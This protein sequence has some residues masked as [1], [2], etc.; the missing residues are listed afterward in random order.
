MLGENPEA[1]ETRPFPVTAPDGQP[2][3][4]SRSLAN[5]PAWQRFIVNIA[6]AMVNI[7]FGFLVMSILAA[8]LPLASTTVGRMYTE[9]EKEMAG[10]TISSADS[11]LQVGD[12]IL[13]VAGNRVHVF[14]QMYYQVVTHGSKPVLLEILRNGEKQEIVVAFPTFEESGMTFGDIDFVPTREESNLGNVCKHAFYKC[15]SVVR[16]V[17]ESFIDLL[18][19]KYTMDAVS[20][21]VGT[22]GAIS[23]AAKLGFANLLYIVVIISVNLGI[24]NLLPIPALDGSHV[25]ISFFEMVT[26]IKVPTRIVATIDMIGLMALL[27]FMAFITFKDISKIFFR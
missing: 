12:T 1:D 2:I 27:S 9:E 11:G 16:M 21:P 24:F 14:D 4:P 3:D 26:G 13:S 17:W 19:G 18:G 25:I 7:L 6:G 22:A 10:Y 8:T 15:V 20:G 5:K 23:D